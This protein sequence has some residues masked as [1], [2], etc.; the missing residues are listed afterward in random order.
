MSRP[1]AFFLVDQPQLKK[2]LS[3]RGSN[4]QSVKLLPFVQMAEIKHE[5][6]SSRAA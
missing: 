1:Q 4:M 6:V 3:A 5:R 2:G